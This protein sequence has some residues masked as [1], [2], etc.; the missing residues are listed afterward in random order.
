MRKLAVLLVA[1]LLSSTAAAA[2]ESGRY[3]LAGGHADTLVSCPAEWTVWEQVGPGEWD[4]K[5]SCWGEDTPWPE[6]DKR[7]VS[8]ILTRAD[9]DNILRVETIALPFEVEL[10]VGTD[11][12]GRY[13]GCYAAP[14]KN[15][16]AYY[17]WTF[18]LIID[19]ENYGTTEQEFGPIAPINPVYSYYP[20]RASAQDCEQA[21]TKLVPASYI[22]QHNSLGGANTKECKV[23]LGG[24]KGHTPARIYLR[25]SNIDR[26]T[27]LHELAHAILHHGGGYYQTPEHHRELPFCQEFFRLWDLY[28]QPRSSVS[29]YYPWNTYVWELEVCEEYAEP[30]QF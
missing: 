22:L 14:R 16:V 3:N 19:G 15:Y 26:V 29:E 13:V 27:F 28:G 20:V 10:I 7:E 11:I 2:Q 1:V 23:R 4:W 8:P 18:E 30:R 12:C 24:Y 25:D 9:A 6:D 5:L 21:Y 17:L